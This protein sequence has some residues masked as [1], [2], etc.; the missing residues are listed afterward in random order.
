VQVIPDSQARRFLPLARAFGPSA[1]R[2]APPFSVARICFL[3]A[4]C[5]CVA[6]PSSAMKTRR[7][8]PVAVLLLWAAAC[9]GAQGG[10]A[11]EFIH[12][13][14]THLLNTAGVA[15]QLVAARNHFNSAADLQK[16]LSDVALKYKPAFGIVTGDLTDTY[17]FEA[18]DGN[19]AGGQIEVF[20][21]V[22]E[23]SPIPLFLTLGNHDLHH[24]A[25]NPRTQKAAPDES[26]AGEA[27]AAWILAARCFERGTYYS[28]EKRTGSARFLFLMLDNGYSGGGSETNGAERVSAEQLQWIRR[29]IELHPD[30]GVIVAMHVPLGDDAGSKAVEMALS[31]SSSIPVVF[32]GHKHTDAI[33]QVHIGSISTTQV[34][35]AAFGYGKQ[36]WRR[37]RLTDQ[38]VDIYATGKP[39]VVEKT[40]PVSRQGRAGTSQEAQR[41]AA[42]Q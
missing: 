34:R 30:D 8:F 22:Y 27:R 21:R 17:T 42:I 14:D 20:R 41:P 18:P 2:C 38:R 15:P 11:V 33:K 10:P 35:T 37:I 25:L 12:I 9:W 26:V 36:N 5:A 3:R 32:C 40:I 39:E 19:P 1:G 16:L 6:L 31:R 4:T 29:Q 7:A 13:T 24:Y 28:F 23:A